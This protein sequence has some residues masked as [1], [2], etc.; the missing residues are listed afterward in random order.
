M[1]HLPPP[2]LNLVE[3]LAWRARN[4]PDELAMVELRGMRGETDKAT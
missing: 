1:A 3:R 2:H 4:Q